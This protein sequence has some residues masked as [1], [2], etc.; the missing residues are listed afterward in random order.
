[1]VRNATNGQKLLD[2]RYKIPQDLFD[3]VQERF[4]VDPQSGIE[5]TRNAAISAALR[6]LKTIKS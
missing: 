4:G 2:H 1:M 3:F 5:R 6:E